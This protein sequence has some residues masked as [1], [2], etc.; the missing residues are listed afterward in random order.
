MGDWNTRPS[1]CQP[2]HFHLFCNALEN[3]YNII[4]L[5]KDLISEP[6]QFRSSENQ[7]VGHEKSPDD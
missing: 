7:E 3:C 1:P 6:E 5:A 4:V 2:N